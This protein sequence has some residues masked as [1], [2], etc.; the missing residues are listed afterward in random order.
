LEGI[1]CKRVRTPLSFIDAI[2][3]L[4]NAQVIKVFRNL[5]PAFRKQIEFTLERFVE[6][7][8]LFWKSSDT[9]TCTQWAKCRLLTAGGKFRYNCALKRPKLLFIN[10]RTSEML[11]SV[12]RLWCFASRYVAIQ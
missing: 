1:S 12:F 10:M 9:H 2:Q 4:N 6:K 3:G 8:S 5:D 7:L 11:N